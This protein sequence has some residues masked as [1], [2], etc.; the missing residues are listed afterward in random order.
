MH[1][2]GT[3]LHVSGMQLL[4]EWLCHTLEQVWTTGIALQRY[5]GVNVSIIELAIMSA[6]IRQPVATVMMCSVY[7]H[8]AHTQNA[9]RSNYKRFDYLRDYKLSPAAIEA[10]NL[11]N[12]RPH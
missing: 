7:N 3:S 5:Y 6:N 11:Q 4:N 9:K 8:M 1:M 12:S 10:I 2:S